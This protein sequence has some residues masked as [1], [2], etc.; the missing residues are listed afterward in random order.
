MKE[1]LGVAV[2]GCGYWGV[3]YV[4]VF[5]ELA[6]ARVE[7]ICDSREERLRE[8][9]RRFPEASLETS[10]TD[11]LQ[12]EGVDAAVICTGATTH[13]DVAARCLE[14]GKHV[15]VE[16]PIA[17]TVDDAQALLDLATSQGVTLMV[18]HTFLYNAGVQKV[19]DYVDQ[20]DLGQL[21]YL[22]ARRTNL[23]PIRHDVNAIWDLA[24]HDISVFNHLLGGE[25]AWVSAVGIRA[26]GSVREDAGFISLGYPGGVVGN[27]HVSW[28]DPNKVREL[29]VVGSD[30]RVAFDDTNMLEQVRVFEKG[31]TLE[32]GEATS[33]GEYHLRMRDGDIISPKVT[34][35]EPLKNQCQHFLDCVNQGAKPR[36][37]ARAGLEVVRTLA[38]IDRST[39]QNG[40]PVSISTPTTSPAEAV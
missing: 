22:Y 18:G 32:Q 1:T 27:I 11:A 6:G 19:K 24:P 5:S 40:A 8:V 2:V 17:T 20:G 23:G 4:R 28:A 33:Y 7:V 29:V 15:L 16:K 21:R 38:A 35:S 12:R 3:N 39:E 25:P 36:T 31:V 34:V 37:D 9:G 26:L 13:H 30:K 14:A 10:L